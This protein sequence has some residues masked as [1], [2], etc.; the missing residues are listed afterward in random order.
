MEI[1]N[2]NKNEKQKIIV[3]KIGLQTILRSDI[4]NPG[5]IESLPAFIYAL[6]KGD[7]S[8]LAKKME[9]I[10]NNFSL[11]I[12][13]LCTDCASGVS[14]ERLLIIKKE[15]DTA[16]MSNV[17]IQWADAVCGKLGID[18]LDANYKK[19]TSCFSPALFITG[20]LDI[21]TPIFQ[22]EEIRMG[23]PNSKHVIVEN[24]GHETIPI[25]QVQK[26]IADFLNDIQTIPS[27][28]SLPKLKFN[29]PTNMN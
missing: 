14:P 2:K 12:M 16:I 17:N 23:F 8:G 7:Y 21:N 13:G 9:A 4:G 26:I 29:L 19:R 3:G 10:Y 1:F 25:E 22:A 5:A 11:S 20:S 27:S 15:T 28:I 24:G 18:R 6:N